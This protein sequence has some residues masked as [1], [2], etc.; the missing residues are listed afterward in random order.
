MILS[1]SNRRSSCCTVDEAREG[2]S[3][4]VACAEVVAKT[5]HQMEVT[6][7]ARDSRCSR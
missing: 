1:Y 2:E 7:S 4:S 3:V 6:E 5:G